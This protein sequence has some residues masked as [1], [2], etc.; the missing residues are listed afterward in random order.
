MS[1]SFEL[2]PFA[3][4]HGGAA[5]GRHEGRI[6]F[7]PYTI[8]GERVRVEIVEDK[9]KYANARVVEVVEPSPDRVKP[10]CQYFGQGLCGGCQFQHI[11]YERQLEIKRNVVQDQLERIGKLK[12]PVV[13]PTI[14]SPTPWQYRFHSTFTILPDGSPAYYRDDNSGLIAI[15][16]CYI[17]H[18][19]LLDLLEQID[20]EEGNISR[21]KM[22]VGSDPTQLMLIIETDDD[23]APGIEEELTVITYEGKAGHY[24]TVHAT[25]EV[26]LKARDI[27]EL[28]GKELHMV[29]DVI[30]DFIKQFDKFKRELK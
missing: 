16:E 7:V 27:D 4:A 24:S 12:D 15:E 25:Y 5:L 21:V 22:Q 29:V 18:P 14:A 1:E 28:G 13:H 10:P 8:P 30:T 19:S 26:A 2:V 20:F 6:I 11:D 9:G 23:L 17:I 3:M